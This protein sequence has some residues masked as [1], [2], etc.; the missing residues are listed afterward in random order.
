MKRLLYIKSNFNRK[1]KYRIITS[2]YKNNGH[3]FV[4]KKPASPLAG[5]HLKN[6]I[7][8]EKHWQ[9][10]IGN[11]GKVI[12]GQLTNETIEYKFL[13]HKTL[14]TLIVDS[15]SNKRFISATKY[16]FIGINII[17]NLPSH[18]INTFPTDKL[19]KYFKYFG[20]TPLPGQQYLDIANL[21]IATDN[22]ILD[23]QTTYFL[24]CEWITDFPVEKNML[25]YRYCLYSALKYRQF[26]K[27]FN[28][29]DLTEFAYSELFLPTKWLMHIFTP[30]EIKNNLENYFLKEENFQAYLHIVKRRSPYVPY[31]KII[32]SPVQ[33][34]YNQIKQI[35][36]SKI[37][38]LW[39]LLK[40][41]NKI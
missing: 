32:L 33:N 1:E 16:F 31:R 30:V 13:N 39:S 35:K 34:S 4:S 20:A 25:I 2:I 17:N 14:D 5:D 6:I 26:F 24:D 27:N 8:S 15:L 23:S 37:F 3:F 29:L 9:N 12:K 36:T 28:K 11:K 21:D 38:R 18:K 10:F 7:V 41:I 40:K 22:L 19:N